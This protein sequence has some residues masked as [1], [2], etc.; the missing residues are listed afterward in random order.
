MKEL[1][2]LIEIKNLWVT[3]NN[4]IILEDINLRVQEN[5][6]IA[7]IG[8]NGGGKTT[9][10][11]VI[12]GLI[13]P[14]RG[15]IKVLGTSP[16]KA[17]KYIGYLPQ[18]PQF[19]LTFPIN[20]FE[21]VLMGRYKGLAKKFSEEDKEA[22]INVLKEVGMLHNKDKQISEL[23]GGEVQRVLLAR[24][25]VRNPHILLLDEP[26]S[27]IDTDMQKT[28]Y[29]LIVQLKKEKAIILVS[30]DVAIISTF[31]EKIACLN[32]KLFFHDLKESAL[33]KLEDIYKC[34]VE[35][36]AHGIPHRVLKNHNRE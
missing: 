34:P 21:V 31:I 15:E 5:D 19:D 17:R 1:K 9:L 18:V 33:K 20:V 3:I 8:P 13:K 10:I 7:L 22:T 26:T 4:T 23:S 14:S 30:H 11:K 24:A 35:V 29:E 2:T 32:R 36:I 16:T 28:F 12:L 27:N 25:L 6:L